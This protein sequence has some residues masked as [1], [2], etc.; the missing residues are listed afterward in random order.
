M[1]NIKSDVRTCGIVPL[2][3]SQILKK[4]PSSDI[5][6]VSVST[7]FNSTLVTLLEENRSCAYSKKKEESVENTN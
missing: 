1:V 4:I 6:V 7:V 3:R 2:D 5:T